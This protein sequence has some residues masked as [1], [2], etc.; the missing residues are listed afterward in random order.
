MIIY[1]LLLD[2][3]YLMV[4]GEKYRDK[5]ESKNCHLHRMLLEELVPKRIR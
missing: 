4:R 1:P 3:A 5:E 2:P